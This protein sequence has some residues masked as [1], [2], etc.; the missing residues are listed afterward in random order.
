MENVINPPV[1]FSIGALSTSIISSIY[2]NN[3]VNELNET[4]NKSDNKLAKL[5]KT[6][7]NDNTK[8]VIDNIRKDIESQKKITNQLKKSVDEL[9]DI[10]SDIDKTNRKL[11]HM[12][13]FLYNKYGYTY[14]DYDDNNQSYTYTKSYKSDNSP[15]PR[16]SK[17][18]Q[19][20]SPQRQSRRS[21]SPQKQSRN[22]S[23]RRRRQSRS[24]SNERSPRRGNE[25][26]PR[27]NMDRSRR[28][29]RS[30]SRS[31]SDDDLAEQMGMV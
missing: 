7:H 25:R 19:S 30:E 8:D 26:S 10:S 13:D 9:Y 24:L 22:K 23:P 17:H 12:T 3:K 6:I 29:N 4:L 16:R 20:I 5:I 21:I 15:S 27:R 14:D 31:E 18:K 11:A 28:R 1:I 2:L